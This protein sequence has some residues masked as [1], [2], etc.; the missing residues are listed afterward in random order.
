MLNIEE[1]AFLNAV[2]LGKNRVMVDLLTEVMTEL[3]PRSSLLKFTEI[4]KLKKQLNISKPHLLIIDLQET[5]VSVKGFIMYFKKKCPA[6]KILIIG[7]SADIMIVRDFFEI[8][9]SGFVSAEISPY[10]LK[11]ALQKIFSGEK[12][13]GTGVSGKLI[14]SFFSFQKRV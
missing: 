5:D 6:L 3:N 8:G 7:S 4:E 13:V 9:I 11:I 1:L 10:E 12:Y 2:I 14:S